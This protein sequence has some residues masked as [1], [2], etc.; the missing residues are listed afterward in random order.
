MALSYRLVAPAALLILALAVAQVSSSEEQ[1][2]T[3]QEHASACRTSLVP[4]P[5]GHRDHRSQEAPVPA[6]RPLGFRTPVA[7]PPPPRSGTPR[8]RMRP[9]H[10][11]PPPPPPPPPPPCS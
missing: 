10:P 4:P 6:S 11:S 2:C 3:G 9:F 5:D 1:R 7:A 8:A